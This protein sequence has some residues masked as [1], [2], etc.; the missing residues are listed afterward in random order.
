MLNWNLRKAKFKDWTV[1]PVACSVFKC[2]DTILDGCHLL[3]LIVFHSN[4]A[5]QLSDTAV[6]GE[7]CVWFHHFSALVLTGF[8]FHSSEHKLTSSVHST[9]ELL[10]FLQSIL[11]VTTI[12]L[13]TNIRSGMFV[14][15]VLWGQ[16]SVFVS[17]LLGMSN[18]LWWYLWV[19]LVGRFDCKNKANFCWKPQDI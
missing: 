5:T 6:C 9:D 15:R 10:A 12:K 2:R 1:S 17:V 8:C 11:K 14:H 13:L 3:E 7:L 4:V 16:V 18:I 19:E